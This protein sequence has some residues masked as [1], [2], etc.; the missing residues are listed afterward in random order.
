MR[1]DVVGGYYKFKPS[2]MGHPGVVRV[3]GTANDKYV[4]E[5]VVS[6]AA[7]TL[8]VG[9]IATIKPSDI[10]KNMVRLTLEEAAAVR[11]GVAT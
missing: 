7:P 10:R 3:L 8:R 1:T 2:V 4:C 5:F 11:L 9:F 6:G